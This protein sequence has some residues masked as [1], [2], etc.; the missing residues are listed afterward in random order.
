MRENAGAPDR[1]GPARLF[2]FSTF[3]ADAC[4]V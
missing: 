2:L 1:V 4:E 3:D